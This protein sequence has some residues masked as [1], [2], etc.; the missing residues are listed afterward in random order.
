MI[1]GVAESLPVPSS[2]ELGKE[3][4]ELAKSNAR[5]ARPVEAARSHRGLIAGG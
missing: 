3:L 4:E 2:R 5:V 1:D